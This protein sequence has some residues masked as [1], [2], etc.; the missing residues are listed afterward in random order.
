MKRAHSK[1]SLNIDAR[2]KEQSRITSENNKL[3]QQLISSKGSVSNRDFL[4]NYN[5]HEKHMKVRS[6]VS[7][8][9]RM[10]KL[11]SSDQKWN[12]L[13]STSNNDGGGR[14]TTRADS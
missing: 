4:K 1:K 5:Q 11:G 7:L 9:D 10:L 12:S 3:M 13:I 2:L 8:I 6:K 14:L